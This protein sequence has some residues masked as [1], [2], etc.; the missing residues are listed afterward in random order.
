MAARAFQAT[1][2]PTA[3]TGLTVGTTYVVQNVSRSRLVNLRVASSAAVVTDPAFVAAP[4]LHSLSTWRARLETG[5]ALYAWTDEGTA[6]LVY[7]VEA[8]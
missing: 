7:D 5:E 2:T 6:A 3:I 1:T 4:F 8:T